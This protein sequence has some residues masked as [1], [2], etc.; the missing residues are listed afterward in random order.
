MPL[1]L[2]TERLL[3]RPARIDDL[4]TW[5]AISR[6]AEEA[7]FGAPSST[8]E[9]AR[10]NLAKHIAHHGQH[11]FG[12]WAVELRATR[13]MIGATGLTHLDDGPEI[14]V[15]YRFLREHWGNGYA[16]EAALAAI[17]FGLDELRLERIVAVT[18]PTNRASQDVM[19][20]CGLTFVGIMNVYGQA[21]VKYAIAR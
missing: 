9:D 18:L 4:D 13:E 3:L 1:P 12:L 8:L 16:T 20:K 17:G 21:Q 14:E 11:G 2:A 10:A 19:E 15:G 5:C 7:W 6:D